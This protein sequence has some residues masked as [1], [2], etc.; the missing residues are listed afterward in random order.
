MFLRKGKTNVKYLFIVIILAVFVGGG[1]FFV[2]G[3]M[4]CS[5][6][7]PSIQQIPPV[8]DKTADWKTYR[9]E[10]YRYELKYPPDWEIE[11]EAHLKEV[12]PMITSPKSAEI[13]GTLVIG[14]NIGAIPSSTKQA[15][16]IDKSAPY[17]VKEVIDEG[18]ITIEGIEGYRMIFVTEYA[19]PVGHP[20]PTEDVVIQKIYLIHNSIL[21]ELIYEEQ[22]NVE[23]YTW[24]K[25][26]KKWAYG[27]IFNQMLSTFRFIETT[28]GFCGS[29]TYGG[30]S[31]DLDCIAGGCSGRVCQSKNEEP[32]I[33]TCEWKDCYD[34]TKYGVTCGCVNNKCLWYKKDAKPSICPEPPSCPVPLIYGDPPFD[35]PNQCPRYHCPAE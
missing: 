24:I 29:S 22:K 25:D 5:S 18:K 20:S 7:W 27:D 32:I 33:T 16:E 19:T 2:I 4:N 28:E 17:F 12:A 23:P 10:E 35:D 26:Y 9:N 3:L 13:K 14:V 6:W 11:M 21:Y 34:D 8:E 1:I 15:A 30:C 31:S